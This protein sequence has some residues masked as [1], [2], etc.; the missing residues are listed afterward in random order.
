M[1]ASPA[2]TPVTAPLALTLATLLFD[3]DQLAAFVTDCVV[4][5]DDVVV[6]ENWVVAPARGAE[7][8]TVTEATVGADGA[9]PGLEGAASGEGLP[10]QPAS[11]QPAAS[12][13]HTA[14]P[15]R[16]AHCLTAHDTA[17]RRETLEA[18]C[19]P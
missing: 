9:L 12:P 19:S 17:P 14:T 1:S 13:A 5:S 6:A 15:Q 18:R 10:A 16:A 8:E 11:S 7:P 4:P 2:A 3:E